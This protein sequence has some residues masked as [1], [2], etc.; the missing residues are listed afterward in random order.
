VSDTATETQTASEQQEE[1]THELPPPSE[2]FLNRELSW[3]D[4]NDR[5][6]ELAEDD[7]VPLLERVKFLAI[8]HTNLDE[9]FMVRVAGLH[10]QVDAGVDEA[11]GDGLDPS[12]AIDEIQR[13]VQE[14]AD[15]NASLWEERLKPELAEHGLKIVQCDECEAPELERDDRR[16]PPVAQAE[17]LDRDQN[18]SGEQGDRQEQVRHDHRPAEVARHGKVAERRLRE[19]AEQDSER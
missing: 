10:D 7:E 2:R 6:V 1:Q 11:G 14:R 17:R 8:Y 18:C 16:R 19:G 3:L 5:V 13:R 12:T 15:R 4:F 9:F